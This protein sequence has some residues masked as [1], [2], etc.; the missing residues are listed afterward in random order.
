MSHCWLQWSVWVIVDYSEVYESLL[1]TVKC[2][3]HCW[4]QWSVWVIVDYSEVYESLLITVKCMSHCWRY[5]LLAG[6]CQ[7]GLQNSWILWQGTNHS[8]LTHRFHWMFQVQHTVS[9]WTCCS[10]VQYDNSKGTI[11]HIAGVSI[12]PNKAHWGNTQG[13]CWPL[14]ISQNASPTPAWL[15]V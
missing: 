13:S 2:M 14:T 12:K 11:L 5:L 15:D 3:S 6:S 4:L 1:I 9:S 10:Q 7:N 8:E